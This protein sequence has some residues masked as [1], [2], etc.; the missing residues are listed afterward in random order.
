VRRW[1]ERRWWGRR[2]ARPKII[3]TAHVV[4]TRRCSCGCES[5]GEFPPEATVPAV[6]GPV[7]SGVGAYLLAHQ[8]LPVART[9]EALGDLVGMEVS[10]GWV[11]GP[12]PRARTILGHFLVDLRYRLMA[13]PVMVNDETGASVDTQRFWFHAAAT[14]ELT[15]ITCHR[16]RG[17]IGMEAA[18]VLAGYGGISVHDRYAQYW[19]FGCRHS[20][21]HAHLLRDLAAVA[22]EP[23]RSPGPRRWPPC[24]W[25]PKMRPARPGRPARPRCPG[26]G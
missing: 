22:S 3:V 24:C 7:V 8:H 21:C 5:A 19:C 2:L 9:A 26:A 16:R 18:G 15:L 14:E 23:R 20:A 4:E 12:L 6:Y 17:R 10:T 1:P 13:S 25:R 11:S